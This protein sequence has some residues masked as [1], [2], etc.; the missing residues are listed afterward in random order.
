MVVHKEAKH[1]DYVVVIETNDAIS[2][3]VT[4]IRTCSH[5]LH[6]FKQQT[7]ALTALDDK[8]LNVGQHQLHPIWLLYINSNPQ[9][10][11]RPNPTET[12]CV[13]LIEEM[14]M[15]RIVETSREIDEF[16]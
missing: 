10:S 1:G 14:L 7:K 4:S 3:D 8:M 16:G 2:K 15:Y 6:T 11:P 12:I 9:K 13:S 5:Q